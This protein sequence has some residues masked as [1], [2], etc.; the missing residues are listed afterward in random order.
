MFFYQLGGGNSNMFGIFI[1]KLGE[2]SLF[3]EYF[4]KGLVQPPTRNTF[5]IFLA[6]ESFSKDFLLA[7]TVFFKATYPTYR[8][9]EHLPRDFFVSLP[10]PPLR[11]VP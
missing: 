1:P 11:Q 5:I 3:D 9:D 7:T 2:D 6:W 4:P 10:S 8:I